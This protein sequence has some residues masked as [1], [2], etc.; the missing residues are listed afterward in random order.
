MKKITFAFLLI[1][2]NIGFFSGCAQKALPASRI[3]TISQSYPGVVKAIENIK[4]R[5]DG[6]LTS[7]AGMIA[8]GVAGNQIGGGSGNDLATMAGVMIGSVLGQKADLR[9]AKRITIQLD[10]GK[11]ITTVLPVTPNNPLNINVGDRVN[12]FITNGRV[13]E[14]RRGN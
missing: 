8:G 1:F 13:T 6:Q 14:I 10:S 4:V 11:E 2:I 12:V 9:D 3:G 5:G 7:I